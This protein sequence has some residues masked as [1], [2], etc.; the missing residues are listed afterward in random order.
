MYF[1]KI[2]SRQL[3]KEGDICIDCY[4]GLI[5]EEEN[6]QDDAILFSFRAKYS[7]GYEIMKTPIYFTI[8][9]VLLIF[10]VVLGFQ[11]N[12]LTGILSLVVYF[13]VFTLYFLLSKIRIQSRIVDLYKNKLVYTRKLHLKNFY[14]IKYK[15]IDEIEF[16]D[17]DQ[18]NSIFS[19]SS[20]W[21]TRLNK[22][23]KMSELFFRLKK[24]E[25]SIISPGFFVKPVYNFK[26]EIMPKVM[27]IMKFTERTEKKRSG[28][29]EMLNIKKKDKDKEKEIKNN[30]NEE[31]QENQQDDNSNETNDTSR[32]S[33]KNT[34][35]KNKKII[36]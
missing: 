2:C 22:K 29:E 20:W 35:D 12:V 17:I 4:E 7:L 16:V 31:K 27:E 26:E 14:E 9:L 36:T 23:H 32:M 30:K 6:Q 33:F 5:E 1:C 10:A 3:E 13:G 8:I 11:T 28:I 34:K 19:Q 21:L 15:D 24:T 25:D 18:K